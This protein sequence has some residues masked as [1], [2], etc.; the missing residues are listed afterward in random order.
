MLFENVHV[1]NTKKLFENVHVNN[2]QIESFV[3][4]AN[5][6]KN[7]PQRVLTKV[8]TETSNSFKIDWSLFE[9]WKNDYLPIWIY[10]F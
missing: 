6:S 10:P 5:I 2:T 9:E 3:R 7:N 8:I 4:F 1:N